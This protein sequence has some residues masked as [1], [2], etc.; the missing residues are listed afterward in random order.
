M[1]PDTILTIEELRAKKQAGKI[2]NKS[3]KQRLQKDD[4]SQYRLTGGSA[5]SNIG[6]AAVRSNL[7]SDIYPEGNGTPRLSRREKKKLRET[8]RAE[9]ELA[10]GPPNPATVKEERDAP[11][12]TQPISGNGKGCQIGG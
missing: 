10:G 1:T 4:E 2:L 12:D 7:P 11:S 3:Q 9:G 5:V 6:E 8:R